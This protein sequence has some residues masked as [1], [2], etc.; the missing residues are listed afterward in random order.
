[1]YRTTCGQGYSQYSWDRIN[2]TN[3]S[4]QELR[5]PSSSQAQPWDMSLVP[6][7]VPHTSLVHV[8]M[9]LQ[10]RFSTSHQLEECLV[11]MQITSSPTK[12]LGHNTAILN[13]F[14]THQPFQG[15]NASTC[16]TTYRGADVEYNSLSKF[17]IVWKS[18]TMDSSWRLST[19]Q[20]LLQCAIRVTKTVKGY[21]LRV[22]SMW[23]GCQYN[24]VNYYSN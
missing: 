15:Q 1:M 2:V 18:F 9:C 5:I 14:E 17:Y 23:S 7:P 4:F 22:L 13:H 16:K 6:A 11:I 8:S 19:V 21:F 20:L 3:S 12:T 24:F 10:P